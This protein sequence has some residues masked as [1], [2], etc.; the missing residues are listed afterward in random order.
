MDATKCFD[1]LWLQDCINS[2][3][4]AGLDNEKLN[5]LYLENKNA[6]I[7]VKFNNKISTR[8]SVK[9]VVMQGSIWEA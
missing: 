6:Q 9:H 4:E 8:I 7:A 3:Y 2:L 5:L 1:K